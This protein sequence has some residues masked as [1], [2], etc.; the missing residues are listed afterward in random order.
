[1]FYKHALSEE[2]S[3][4]QVLLNVKGF[5]FFIHVSANKDVKRTSDR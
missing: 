4:L 3:V 5:F 1:M 2:V